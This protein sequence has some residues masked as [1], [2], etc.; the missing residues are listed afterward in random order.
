MAINSK[1]D[2]DLRIVSASRAGVI[3]SSTG[4]D[5]GLG[6]TQDQFDSIRL[7]PEDGLKL[8][9]SRLSAA[10]TLEFSYYDR[11]VPIVL[12]M[13]DRV[14][15]NVD[16]VPVFRGYLFDKRE[17]KSGLIRA[18][19]YDCM[20][21]LLNKDS[22]VRPAETYRSFVAWVADQFAFKCNI[23]NDQWDVVEGAVAEN[24]SY[25]DVMTKYR[26]N[27]VLK[28]GN[29]Y[30]VSASRQQHG[31]L[32]FRSMAQ[33]PWR[34]VL[35]N[36]MVEDYE[37]VESID[38]DDVANMIDIRYKNADDSVSAVTRTN[39]DLISTWGPLWYIEEVDMSPSD[40]ATYANVLLAL[41]S[42]PQRT[43]KLTNVLTDTLLVEAGSPVVASFQLDDRKIESWMLIDSIA[44]TISSTLITADIVLLGNG[45]NA[46]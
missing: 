36:S 46:K 1:K 41:M 33:Y 37:Y 18:T 44:Y 25:L 2:I 7:H 20:R 5:Y 39:K 3:T 8:S 10:G 28:T 29:F 13:G 30:E 42:E 9:L 21:Y 4:G 26:R 17:D 11:Q 24:E 34:V 35:N 6:Y 15:L 12:Q 16:G 40:A 43:F 31:E 27:V 38:N 14:Y 32:V 19:A 22:Y 45:I 23:V